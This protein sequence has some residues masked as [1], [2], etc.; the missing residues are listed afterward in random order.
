MATGSVALERSTA[1]SRLPGA[2][3]ALLAGLRGWLAT[4]FWWLASV[5]LFAGLW[6]LAWAVGWADPLLLPPPHVFLGDF[7]D[8][9]QHFAGPARFEIG[10]PPPPP[11]S[12]IW[13][14][15]ATALATTGRVLA[16]TGLAFVLGALL[17]MLVRYFWLVGRLVLPTITLLAP[18]SPVAWQPVAIFLF[19]IGDRPAIFMVFIAVFFTMVLATISQ[20]DA[21]DRTYR[22]VARI[23]G[24]SRRQLYWH[25]YLPA[26]LPGLFVTLRLNLFAAW[27]VVLIAEVVGVGS[28]LGQIVMMARNTFN[29]GLVFFTIVIIGLTGYLLDLLFRLAQRRLLW[30]VPAGARG[31]VA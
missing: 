27:M 12:R 9:A 24:A 28:G 21:V 14:V 13:S 5:G 19:G 22:D 29:P 20:L 23:M 6:E 10:K 30:W 31:G 15:V 2:G 25:V 7:M 18:V 8:Q 1:R 26:I 17:G 3:R 4:A 16:G 11:E